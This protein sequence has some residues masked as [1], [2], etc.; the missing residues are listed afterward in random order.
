MR[1]IMKQLHFETHTNPMHTNPTC[2]QEPGSRAARN[3]TYGRVEEGYVSRSKVAIGC[4]GAASFNG[5]L[6]SPE[7]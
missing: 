3:G 2:G 1:A 6:I 5:Q 7:T 4:L